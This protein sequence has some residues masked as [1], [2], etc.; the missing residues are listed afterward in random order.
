MPEYEIL[1]K[2]YLIFSIQKKK[3]RNQKNHVN[4]IDFKVKIQDNNFI[5]YST[6][7]VFN[8]KKHE[9]KIS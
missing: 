7:T 2:K 6:L 9:R 8:S 3:Y 5:F 4:N 1:V